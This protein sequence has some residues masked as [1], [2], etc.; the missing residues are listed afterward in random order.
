MM[1]RK[2]YPPAWED[3]ARACKERAGWECEHCGAKQHEIR[4]SKKG[5]PYFVY[6]HAA[7]KRDDKAELTPDLMCLCISCHARYDYER[8]QREARVRLECLKH[9]R[10]LVKQGL[11]G[12]RYIE[13]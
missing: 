4:T 6:L 12:M 5:N 7:H 10:L 11:V 8:K 2:L 1:Y 3:L 9:F 13:G